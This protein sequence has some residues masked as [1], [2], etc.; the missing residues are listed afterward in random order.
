[1]ENLINT[2][3]IKNFI[4]K[5]YLTK[6]AFSNIAKI[7]LNDLNKLLKNNLNVDAVVLFKIAKVVGVQVYEL[8]V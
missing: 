2:K 7:R 8:F 4:K 3:L 6:K 5:N 1:M